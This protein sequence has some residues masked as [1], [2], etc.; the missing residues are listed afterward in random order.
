MFEKFTSGN[1]ENFRQRYEGTYGFYRDEKGK[2]TLAQIES[3]SDREVV[4]S[5]PNVEGYRLKADTERDIGFEF[6]PPKSAF[7]NTDIGAMLVSRIAARQFQRGLSQRNVQITLF[8]GLPY[9][10]AIDF[11]TLTRIFEKSLDPKSALPAF[12]AGT[13]VSLAVSPQICLDAG[14]GKVY[15]LTEPVGSWQRNGKLYNVKL[16]DKNLFRTEITDAFKAL[17]REVTFI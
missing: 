6:L 1:W 13:T 4:F 7:H 2:R 10:Q 8:K 9:N 15:V 12:E 16:N 3:V 11:N 5:L 14:C 17:G